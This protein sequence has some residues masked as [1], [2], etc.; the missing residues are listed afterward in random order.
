MGE[1]VEQRRGL[2]VL[3][4]CAVLMCSTAVAVA[5]TPDDTPADSLDFLTPADSADVSNLDSLLTVDS[6]R[7]VH[8]F[9]HDAPPLG[10]LT[11]RTPEPGYRV[12]N[13]RDLV[14]RRYFTA[15]DVLEH[16]LPAYPVS[17]GTPGLVRAFSYGG[18]S[19]GSISASFNGRPLLAQV[20]TGYDLENYPMEF[21]DRIEMVYGARAAIFGTGESLIALN[22]VQPEYDVEG[23]YS[24][25]WYAQGGFGLTSGDLLYSRNLSDRANITI[26]FR[27]L[28]SDGLFPNQSVSNTDMRGSLRWNVPGDIE[29]SLTHMYTNVTRG[30]NGGLRL[31]SSRDPLLASVNAG[32]TEE[33]LRHDLTLSVRWSPERDSVARTAGLPRVDASAYY[34]DDHRLILNTREGEYDAGVVGARAALFMPVGD[35]RL[36]ANGILEARHR[37]TADSR[38][39]LGWAFAQGGG[40]LEIPVGQRITLRGG[41]RLDIDADE[42]VR[43]ILIGEMALTP[44]DSLTIRGTVRLFAGGDKTPLQD[45]IPTFSDTRT[46]LLAEASIDWHD[47]GA[48]VKLD[49]YYRMVDALKDSVDGDLFGAAI[50]LQL[51]IAGFLHFNNRFLFTIAPAEDERFPLVYA[52]HDVYGRWQLFNDNLDLRIG[53]TA[54]WQTAFSSFDYEPY[55]G[56]MMFAAD[57][58]KEPVTLFP[59]LSVYAQARIGNAFLRAAMTNVLGNEFWTLLRYPIPSRMI[60]LEVTWTLID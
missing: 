3:I 43:T 60:F 28:P 34:T 11:T 31:T 53:T 10:S 7:S 33:Q 17:Q 15:F 29:L 25:I 21:V 16:D 49:G 6:S 19:P 32:L 52:F 27:R 23:S 54:R 30:L 36:V 56:D 55:S 47:A 37:N 46:A 9:H 24:R 41:A 1:S 5:Q 57:R 51:P 14:W 40:L 22:F 13:D 26:G 45:S 39:V 58:I 20:G 38:E 42:P 12:I 18:A 8:P 50:D 2:V 59:D 48:S 44:T 4:C 35:V